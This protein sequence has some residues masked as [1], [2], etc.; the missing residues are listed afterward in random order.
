[1]FAISIIVF[2]TWQVKHLSRVSFPGD[3]VYVTGVSIAAGR[4]N[5]LIRKCFIS[6]IKVVMGI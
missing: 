4:I 6:L 1:M 5:P 2:I 3:S